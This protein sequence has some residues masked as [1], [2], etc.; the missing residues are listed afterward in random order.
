M[1][2]RGRKPKPTA[3]KVLEGNPGKRKL[4]K[5][6]PVAEGDLAIPPAFLSVTQ[7]VIWVN[8]LR[9]APKGLLKAVDEAVLAKYC[10]AYDQFQRSSEDIARNG[11]ETATQNGTTVAPAVHVQKKAAQDMSS[12]CSEMGFTPSSRSRLH[13]EDPKD[14]SNPFENLD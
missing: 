1:A 8:T 5:S 14:P 7:R 12:A 3:V 6:E 10:V 2:T 9:V 4:N 11:Y 13:L